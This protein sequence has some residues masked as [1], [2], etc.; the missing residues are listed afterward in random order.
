MNEKG[1]ALTAFPHAVV[2]VARGVCRRQSIERELSLQTARSIIRRRRQRWLRD[3]AAALPGDLRLRQ[4]FRI[5]FDLVDQ[6]FKIFVA[7]SGPRLADDHRRVAHEQ[8]A[9][10]VR[11]VRLRDTV[12]VKVDACAAAG[13]RL[14]S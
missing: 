3:L 9:D 1:W 8:R 10:I 4:G 7:L 2:A 6:P 5:D 14:P 12:H 11:R 13:L